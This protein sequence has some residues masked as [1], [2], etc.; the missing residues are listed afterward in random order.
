MRGTRKSRKKKKNSPLTLFVWFTA[1]A[2]VTVVLLEYI[3][4]KK[5][6]KSF[7]FNT[8][9][10]LEKKDAGVKAFNT[11]LVALLKKNKLPF[12]YF[13]DKDK[14]YHFKIDVTQARY[15][16]LI[17]QLKSLSKRLKGNIEL[18]E[19]QGLEN[20][21]IMLFNVTLG[22]RVTHLLLISRYKPVKPK[23]KAPVQ[24]EETQWVDPVEP[25]PSKSPRLAFIIDDVGA[26]DIGPLQFKRLN[27]P[28]TA[29][30]L[31]NSR[32]AR[33]AAYWAGQYKLET[34]IHLPMQP[35]KS[36]GVRFD[37]KV[38]VTLD[39]TDEEIRALIRKAKRIIPQAGGLNN[40]QGSLATSNRTLMKR[41][42]KIIKQEKLFFIDSRTIGSTVAYETAKQFNVP[43]THKDIFLDH[44][45]TYAHSMEQIKKLV[46][47]ARRKGKAIA[48]GHPFATT[49][50][51]IRDSIKYIRSK[52]V[53]IVFAKELLEY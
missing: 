48:I 13:A 30:V 4:Y 33:D 39:S 36:N 28:I 15:K 11:K 43:T 51:A 17:D 22:G 19:I 49:I 37:K 7:I 1:I 34:M 52:G 41:V 42:M 29:S 26:Y 25:E 40:H 18:A 12:D 20:K 16:P 21:S 53:T 24:K 5:G 23:E 14:K 45:Q 3:D 9:V 31:P 8:L 50:R 2:V 6:G 35:T 27:I 44:V 47:V 32:R 46:A 38:T 10:P